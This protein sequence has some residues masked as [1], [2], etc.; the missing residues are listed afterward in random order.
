APLSL[1]R[2]D[3]PTRFVGR[4]IYTYAD[5]SVNPDDDWQENFTTPDLEPGL[6]ELAFRYGDAVRRELV[7]VYPNQTAF[8]TIQLDTTP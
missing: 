8:I 2:A 3:D 4:T 5:G 6:Y 7:W 1:R